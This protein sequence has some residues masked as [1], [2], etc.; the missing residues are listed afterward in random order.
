MLEVSLRFSQGKYFFGRGK[1]QKRK[2]RRQPNHN[3][4]RINTMCVALSIYIDALSE[5]GLHDQIGVTWAQL[6]DHGFGF[7][8]HNW[9]H[10]AVALVRAGDVE[11]AFRIMETVLLPHGRRVVRIQERRETP[12]TPLSFED[13]GE[14]DREAQDI[15][16]PYEEALRRT[17]ERALVASHANRIARTFS[18]DTKR[19]IEEHEGDFAQGL[20]VLRQI[21][22]VWNAWAPHDRTLRAL[23][24]AVLRLESGVLPS[25]GTTSVKFDDGHGQDHD[26]TDMLSRGAEERQLV[27]Y[28]ARDILGRIYR[29]Y[30]Q[31]V[32]IVMDFERREKRRLRGGFDRVYR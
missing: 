7:D 23:L 28:Q 8:A 19:T 32:R 4:P 18:E 12:D 9:N 17:S 24:S 15:S 27:S 21:L 1:D 2:A 5:A 22:P 25:T 20:H 11:R 26:S 31:T 30:P 16:K 10:L 3:L 29:D 13:A 14:E 6:Q